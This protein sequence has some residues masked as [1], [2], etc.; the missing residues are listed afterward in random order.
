[1]P[2]IDEFVD[3]K[4]STYQ[5]QLYI[6]K[7][8]VFTKIGDTFSVKLEDLSENSNVMVNM[9]CDYCGDSFK[10]RYMNYIR[11]KKSGNNKCCCIKCRN[12]KYEENVMNKYG[13]KNTAILDWV[14]DKQMKTCLDRYGVISTSMVD[15]VR[16]KMAKSLQ[17]NKSCKKSAVQESICKAIG[18]KMNV[19]IYGKVVDILLDDKIYI[20]YDG[21]GHLIPLKFRAMNYE[22]FI[23]REYNRFAHLCRHGYK[24]IKLINYRDI[25]LDYDVVSQIIYKCVF[26][27]KNFDDTFI[28]LDLSDGNFLIDNYC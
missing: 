27:L 24:M 12:K 28:I 6:D 4:W 23:N 16:E 21:G 3:I 20:E 8:Y 10:Q 1:M 19:A 15:S 13:V 5:K 7:G 9:I 2:I 18:G 26:F 22:R 25:K 17:N 11:G 14:K